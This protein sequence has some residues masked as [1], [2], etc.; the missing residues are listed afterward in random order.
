MN[1]RKF[2]FSTKNESSQKLLPIDLVVEIE[3]I[4]F[5]I[6]DSPMEV[7]IRANYEVI[8]M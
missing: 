5:Q 3:E 6:E 8:I 1:I 2:V 7:K 4:V